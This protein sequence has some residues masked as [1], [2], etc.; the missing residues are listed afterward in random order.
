MLKKNKYLKKENERLTKKVEEQELI[1]KEQSEKIKNLE[2]ENTV[3]KDEVDRLTGK[4][5]KDSVNSSIPPSKDQ[6]RKN[7]NLRE[8]TGKKT[9][10]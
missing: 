9:G 10:G 6:K 7:I 8:K 5:I 4:S 2:R 3:L 1:I